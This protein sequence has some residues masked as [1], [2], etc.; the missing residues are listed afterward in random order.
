M[1]TG[2][3]VG[4][5]LVTAILSACGAE[6][7]SE[8]VGRESSEIRR[9][10][11]G[12]VDGDGVPTRRDNCPNHPNADQADGDADG[13]GDACDPD[14]GP[15]PIGICGRPRSR[16]IDDFE[17]GDTVT[18]NGMGAWFVFND[19]TGMQIPATLDDLVV[20]GGPGRSLFAAR[21]S[22]DGFT[23]FGA[24]FGVAFG[25]AI[26]VKRFRGVKFA[27]K[28]RGARRFLFEVPTLDGVEAQFGGRC[29]ENCNDFYQTELATENDRWHECSIAFDD[30]T[31]IGFGTPVPFDL[32]I[33]TGVQVNITL[34][35]LPYDVTLDDLRF[36]RHAVTGCQPIRRGHHRHR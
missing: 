20:R 28:A 17:D 9:A 33:V 34:A 14:I 22:G 21:S 6:P 2:V 19:G 31:Q 1:K 24:G 26:D 3:L 16:L 10:H 8:P 5:G 27:A 23:V 32:G 13:V 11:S 4:I 36:V 30:L 7:G 29:T 15:V 25:C 18:P 35:Q 12:D